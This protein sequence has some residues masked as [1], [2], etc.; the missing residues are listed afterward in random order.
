MDQFTS[1]TNFVK[2]VFRRVA[3]KYDIM[4]DIMSLGIHR[5]WKRNFIDCLSI[6]WDGHYVD[7]ATG[8]GDVVHLIHKKIV[9]HGLIPNITAVDPNEEMLAKGQAKLIDKGIVQGV[10]WVQAF[11]EDLPLAD[12]SACAVTI[13]FG[14]RNVTEIPKALA[15]FYRVLKPGGQFLCLEFSRLQHQSLNALYQLYSSKV[16]SKVGKLVAKDEAAYKY[17]VESIQQFPDQETLKSMIE[18]AGFKT[19]TYENLTDGIVAIHKGWK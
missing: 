11:A 6:K 17:L 19:V 10:N 9:K 8:T 14:L 15:E 7:V 12:N 18:N 13:S 16:I 2:D 1:H 3:D 5:I 4:N